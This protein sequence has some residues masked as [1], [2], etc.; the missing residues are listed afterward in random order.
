MFFQSAFSSHCSENIASKCFNLQT[1]PRSHYYRRPNY[2]CNH[3]WAS[4]RRSLTSM[5]PRSHTALATPNATSTKK[6]ATI[7]AVGCTVRN[8]IQA[9]LPSVCRSV[10]SAAGSSSWYSAL[11]NT[12]FQAV[13]A[14][15]I[16]TMQ[17]RR[18]RLDFS[19]NRANPGMSTTSDSVRSRRPNAFPR[20]T[21]P[22]FFV[23]VRS[24]PR[25]QT[26]ESA[27]TCTAKPNRRSRGRLSRSH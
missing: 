9:Q 10:P 14:E 24:S 19:K 18:L 25:P 21:P 17:R 5:F 13:K 16:V 12:I 23:A 6:S 8:K 22:K 27:Y 20:K 15:Q 11:A 7:I 4:T 1:K 3:I 26:L 2:L